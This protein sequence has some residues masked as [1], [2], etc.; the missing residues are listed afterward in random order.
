MG[1]MLTI[2]GKPY[3]LRRRRL[4]EIPSQWLGKIPTDLT[5][6]KRKERSKLKKLRNRKHRHKYGVFGVA[7]AHVCLKS[8]RP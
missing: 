7:G 4:V 1:K 5:I 2:E 8:T 6:R 3:R